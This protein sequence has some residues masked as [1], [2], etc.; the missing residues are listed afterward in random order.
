MRKGQTKTHC[1]N[2]HAL[3]AENVRMVK[4]PGQGEY[5]ACK[6]CLSANTMRHRR[7]KPEAMEKARAATRRWNAAHRPELAAK[8]RL[9]RHM[10][11][12]QA[13]EYKGGCCIDCGYN[14][15]LNGL[16]FDH[17]PGAQN[18]TEVSVLLPYCRWPRIQEELDK[19]DLV[20]GTCHNVRT[21]DRRERGVLSQ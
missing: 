12:Y 1:I 10:M 21:A 9:K 17:L 19:C 8:Y 5:Q 14:T 7:T 16:E 15:N 13:V 11:F 6:T 20:C 4:H 3:T 2:N 18:R